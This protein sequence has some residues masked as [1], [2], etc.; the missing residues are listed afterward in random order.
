MADVDYDE[1]A[2][3]RKSKLLY[4]KIKN[5][6]YS[7]KVELTPRDCTRFNEQYK[8]IEI[9]NAMMYLKLRDESC[10]RREAMAFASKSFCRVDSTQQNFGPPNKRIIKVEPG[11]QKI[12]QNV[13][14]DH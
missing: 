6:N 12:T 1:T 14:S 5:K 8:D 10:R 7:K 2:P 13:N 11:R 4:E 3:G 9:T